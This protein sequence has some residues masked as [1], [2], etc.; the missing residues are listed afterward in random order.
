MILGGE[1]QLFSHEYKIANWG[2]YILLIFHNRGGG[3]PNSRNKL[4]GFQGNASYVEHVNEATDRYHRYSTHLTNTWEWMSYHWK[5][6][7][8]NRHKREDSICMR[9]MKNEVHQFRCQQFRFPFVIGTSVSGRS[10]YSVR[11]RTSFQAHTV[12]VPKVCLQ[13]ECT[14][15]RISSCHWRLSTV[16]WSSWSFITMLLDT[17]FW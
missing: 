4:E 6:H 1:L 2:D 3:I 16:D 14:V 5:Y 7:H 12:D 13:Q 11:H 15:T 10:A 17:P 8:I 9:K